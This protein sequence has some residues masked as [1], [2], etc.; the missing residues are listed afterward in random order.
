[1]AAD[2][3]P[4]QSTPAENLEGFTGPRSHP[5]A[6]LARLAALLGSARAQTADMSDLAGT[7]GPQLLHELGQRLGLAIAVAARPIDSLASVDCPCVVMLKD[8]S[9]RLLLDA[10]A[11]ADFIVAGDGD[12]RHPIPRKVLLDVTTGAVFQAFRIDPESAA[13]AA[14]PS[15]AVAGDAARSGHPLLR[16]LLAVAGEKKPL[17]LALATAGLLSGIINLAV[18]IFSMAVFDRVIPH[19]AFETLWALLLGVSL[20]LVLDLALR[21]VRHALG[22]A[23]S[24]AASTRF[25]AAFYSRLLQAPVSAVPRQ[26][27]GLIQP[28]NEM[29]QASV[30]GPQF[31]AGLMVDLP[32]FLIVL[33]FLAALGGWIAA[34]PAVGAVLLFAIHWIAHRS[35][36]KDL[37]DDA[38]LTQRQTQMIVDAVAGADA[39]RLTGSGPQQLMRWEER[40]DAAAIVGHVLRS[41]QNFAS[42]C[43]AF[44]MQAVTVLTIAAGAYSVTAS[45]MTVGALSACMMLSSRAIMPVATLM[46]Q[47]FRLS[48]LLATTRLVSALAVSPVE[49]AGD[50]SETAAQRPIAGRLQLSGVD[51]AHPGAVDSVLSG[52]SLSIA[53]G[54]RIGIVGKSGSGKSTLLKLL[55][56]LFEP[57]LGSIHVDGRDIRQIDPLALRKALAMMA[58]DSWLFDATLEA[59]LRSGLGAV[60]EEWFAKVASITGVADFADRNPAGYSLEVGPGG[61][62]LSGGERQSVALARTLMA[63]PRL[64]ILDEPTSAMDNERE[65]RIIRGL[66]SELRSGELKGMGLIIATHRL[67]ILSL[68][69]RVI[70]M[71]GGRIVADGPKREIFKKFG[72]AA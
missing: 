36:M 64:L 50:I 53:A 29:N 12:A 56:R 16:H 68:V 1:M 27:G 72:I 44:V 45:Q 63:K 62:K 9:S 3:Q 23:V 8:G 71:D 37:G 57:T 33:G 6:D 54:E 49:R 39:I 41:N 28:Y 17:V 24:L 15:P 31:I 7:P 30:I 40:A 66:A 32:F 22:D 35:Q 2:E 51:F 46:T 20:L 65:T 10:P 47:G 14:A 48:Q 21:H 5:L 61:Q 34:I 18:P 70:W 52:I 55:V 38:R 42:H 59:N 11:G 19:G 4:A 67:P 69:D 43:G 60:P 26:A 13:E 58:Q 25:G